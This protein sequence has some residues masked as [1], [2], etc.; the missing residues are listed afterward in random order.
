MPLPLAPNS[1]YAAGVSRDEPPTDEKSPAARS[2]R[3][4]ELREKIR[5]GTY[6][7]D[8]DEL[9]DALLA[10]EPGLSRPR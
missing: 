3:V 2:A 5:A 6:A 7:V 1:R 4:R 10:R 8:A 9:A